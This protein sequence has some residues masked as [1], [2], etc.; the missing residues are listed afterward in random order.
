MMR[1]FVGREAELETLNSVYGKGKAVLIYGRRRVGKTTLIEK[2]CEGRPTLF[3][4]CLD[5][6]LR[7]NLDY[8]HHMIMDFRKEDNGEYRNCLDMEK[9]LARVCTDGNNIIVIDEYQYLLKADGSV[10]SLM[11]HLIDETLNKS[12][13]T[14]I[15]CGSS[16][17]M[18]KSVGED[19]KDLLHGRFRHRIHLR[20]LSLEECRVF[21][22]EMPDHEQMMLYLTFGGVPRYHYESEEVSFESYL[23]RNCIENSWMA[24]EALFLMK[25]DH[26]SSGDYAAV[27]SAIARGYA[28][29]KWISERAGIGTRYV[30]VV[31]KLVNDE[32]LGIVNPML[33]APKRPVYFIRDDFLAFY[34]GVLQ[35]RMDLFRNKDSKKVYDE[36]Y[37]YLKTFMGMRFELYCHDVVCREYTVLDIGRW[38]MDDTKRDIHEDIDIVARLSVGRFRV[39]LFAECKFTPKKV[40]FSQ[41]NQLEKRV[42]PFTSHCNPCLM[43]I[44][45]SGFEEEFEEYARSTGVLLVGPEELYGHRPFPEIGL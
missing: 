3:I 40:G 1:V 15:L 28:I 16:V 35:Y 41:Y 29:P 36:L 8:I 31:R 27:L 10:D 30:E 25:A 17:S 11:Q 7:S 14:L 18:M 37:P 24:D 20:P 6:T 22:P 4:Q 21:H 44:S 43:I 39:D 13:S 42:E 26:P 32:V 33:G 34:F 12:N 5:S 23:R 38:W 2:F 9:D 45:E 19:G